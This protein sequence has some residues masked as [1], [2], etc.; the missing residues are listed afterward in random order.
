MKKC[1]ASI[2]L[3]V[4]VFLSAVVPARAVDPSLA[5]GAASLAFSVIS[6][7][8]D[9]Y[10]SDKE[11]EEALETYKDH[12]VTSLGAATGYTDV[13]Y[14]ELSAAIFDLSESMQPAR[15]V[16]SSAA[17]GY[18]IVATGPFGYHSV[19]S[20]SGFTAETI[21]NNTGQ[22]F[23]T[24]MRYVFR[25]RVDTDSEISRISY[26]VS[27]I[28]D[29]LAKWP[30]TLST[31]STI[32]TTLYNFQTNVQNSLVKLYSKLSNLSDAATGY[33]DSQV[34][35]DLPTM[36]SRMAHDYYYGTADERTAISAAFD[37]YWLTS[38]SSGKSYVSPEVLNDICADLNKAN[39]RCSVYY[40]ADL[41]LS[42]IKG[43]GG[44]YIVDP[45]DWNPS[46]AAYE[47]LSTSNRI[48]A[49]RELAVVSSNRNLSYYAA[50]ASGRL[51]K[52]V[53]SVQYTVADLQYNTW[54]QTKNVVTKLGSI[55]IR[56]S[57]LHTDASS[58]GGKLDNI[59]D[60]LNTTTFT[61]GYKSDATGT[62]YPTQTIPY[63]MAVQ[64]AARINSELLGKQ[65]TVILRDGSG[66]SPV[67]I[68][69]CQIDSNGYI[70]VRSSSNIYYL[71][72][73]DNTIFV[74][75]QDYT[76]SIYSRLSDVI[77]AVNNL[78]VGVDLSDVS[79]SVDA[80]SINLFN[81]TAYCCG[82]LT[83]AD[84]N[85]YPVLPIPYDAATAIVER[86]NTDYIDK[87][88][89]VLQRS[90]TTFTGSVKHAYISSGGVINLRLTNGYGY[91]LCDSANTIYQVDAST[92]YGSRANET[93]TGVS[94]RLDAIIALMQATGGEYTCQH[95]Y[96]QEM[97]QEPTCI[98]PGLMVSTC[99]KCG[100]S[101][102]EIV[103]ALDHDWVCTEHVEAVTDPDTEEVTRAAYDIYTCSR[104]GQTF[105]DHT[106]DGAPTDYGE[107]S[108]AKI[109]IKLFAKLGTFVGK[110]ISWVVDLFTKTL[111]GIN[112]LFARF[113][114][115][116]TQI[117]SFG[118]D[119]PAWLTGFWGVLSSDLQLALSFAFLCTFVGIIGKKL[120]FS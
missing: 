104:C 82:Y 70:Y 112:D 41:G 107:T 49:V 21:W 44:P 99:A 13:T 102:S 110:I 32:S 2:A 45:S 12:W 113:T 98:L 38:M 95:T 23:C 52:T 53:D 108:I 118:G 7:W 64:I 10:A 14:N 66:T 29:T 101:Y 35:S 51:L 31:V 59:A 24:P 54:Q 9:K 115:L 103:G 69:R 106:G 50:Q 74:A 46:G 77:S 30:S 6:K 93:L 48:F 60:L 43:L 40:D 17:G 5:I 33:Y 73:K 16:Y 76:K 94:S 68:S 83:D 36:F 18:V 62:A 27:T 1:V 8:E 117:T 79:L 22:Y 109:I 86:L 84:G 37:R 97:E 61:C 34:Y 47:A 71:C 96:S 57:T 85:K 63:N 15:I 114:E 88:I 67:T 11:K 72:G 39:I 116:T 42:Y 4:L 78:T 87:K 20:G 25:A 111:G 58:L 89:T 100:N 65:M 80:S 92:N 26:A 55:D 105:E 19:R 90:G 120:F 75:D 56:L 81:N 28:S 3:A 91:A 119:Y